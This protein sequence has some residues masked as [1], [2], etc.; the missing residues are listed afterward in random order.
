MYAD[1]RL[2]NLLS[3][4]ELV[5]DQSQPIMHTSNSMFPMCQSPLNKVS[6]MED[7]L[8][9]YEDDEVE[10]V[11]FMYQEPAFDAMNLENNLSSLR[12]NSR[13]GD[14]VNFAQ[15]Y[16]FKGSN[17][18]DFDQEFSQDSQQ[19]DYSDDEENSMAHF[20]G[21]AIEGSIN[22]NELSHPV[23]T[24]ASIESSKAVSVQ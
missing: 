13:V 21:D 12:Y 5:N 3:C 9:N 7:T 10:K 8:D 4:D 24:P 19:S 16:L 20:S 6:H 15:K 11:D 14:K 18:Q 23:D 2:S 22:E 17:E 1:Q